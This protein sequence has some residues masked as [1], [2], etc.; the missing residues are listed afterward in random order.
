MFPVE[1]FHRSQRCL[2]AQHFATRQ[3]TG[4]ARGKI[5]V[6]K[7]KG[8]GIYELR[9]RGHKAFGMVQCIREG[10]GLAQYH[11]IG[12]ESSLSAERMFICLSKSSTYLQSS[13][14]TPFREHSN[15]IQYPLKTYSVN[16]SC[17]ASLA[18]KDPPKHYPN[19]SV[20]FIT[21]N[22]NNVKN[23]LFR[24]NL[25]NK[26]LRSDWRAELNNL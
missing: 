7:W 23:L 10:H 2:I 5:H 3:A 16:S 15:P 24:A 22:R 11:F 21:K 13:I 9:P 26:H 20:H 1:R 6:R 19:H 25:G 17:N 18:L 12:E 14:H 8:Q 4:F